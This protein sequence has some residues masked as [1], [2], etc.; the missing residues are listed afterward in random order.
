MFENKSD[1]ESYIW[2][3]EGRK[4]TITSSYFLSVA[5]PTTYG[6]K[7]VPQR[8]TP[9]VAKWVSLD[10]LRCHFMHRHGTQILNSES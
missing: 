7:C 5:I 10:V 1:N 4:E 3:T 6:G 2:G 9:Q 8:G